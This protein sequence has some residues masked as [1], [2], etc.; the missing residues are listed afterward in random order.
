[1]ALSSRADAWAYKRA[2]RLAFIRPGKPV[3]NCY[4]ESFNGRLRDECLNEH[5]F[6]SMQHARSTI[7]AWRVEYNTERPHSSLDGQIFNPGLHF[8]SVLNR[9]ACQLVESGALRISPAASTRRFR[10]R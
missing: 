7:E 2:V 4:I 8:D 10:A 9:G 6:M 5:W 1:M 3:D